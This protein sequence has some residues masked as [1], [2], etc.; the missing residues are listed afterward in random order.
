MSKIPFS[1]EIQLFGTPQVLLNGKRMD[2]LRRK[3]RALIYYIAAQE[4]G[5]T[6]DKILVF[7]WPDHERSAAQPIL[8]NMI[9]KVR[10]SLG[11]T[12][13]V[14]DQV[15]AFA[16]DTFVDGKFFSAILNSPSSDLQQLT[17]ALN[18]YK[19]DFLDG[20]SRLSASVNC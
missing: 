20:F 19:G 13:Q 17:D 18:L 15:I 14:D 4:G 7:F 10:K 12:F 8:R 3:N 16:P 6:R 11:D 5:S 2:D 1:L 9:H